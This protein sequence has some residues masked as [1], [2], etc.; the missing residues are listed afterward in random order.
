MQSINDWSESHNPGEPSEY[1]FRTP[2]LAEAHAQWHAVHGRDTLC[3]LD[4]GIG[5][6][7]DEDPESTTLL[8]RCGHCQGR[9]TVAEVKACA[10]SRRS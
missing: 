10:A 3:P 7:Y 8:V 6:T 2:T 1:D 5:E 9:H 4:C